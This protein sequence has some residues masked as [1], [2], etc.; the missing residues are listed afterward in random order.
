MGENIFKIKMIKI[1]KIKIS[2]C[3]AHVG[4]FFKLNP[5]LCLFQFQM[6]SGGTV[7]STSWN[8]VSQKKVEVKPPDGVEWKQWDGVPKKEEVKPPAVVESKKWDKQSDKIYD[9]KPSD[10]MEWKRQNLEP[11]K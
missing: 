10:G 3:N 9:M 11:A 2:K 1:H 5:I 7:L 6:E 4:H 8:E